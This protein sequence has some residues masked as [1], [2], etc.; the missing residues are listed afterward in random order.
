MAIEECAG[1]QGF[2]DRADRGG[3]PVNYRRET[4]T[5]RRSPLVQ[6]EPADV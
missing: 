6:L 2:A 4:G 1:R 5:L 3:D